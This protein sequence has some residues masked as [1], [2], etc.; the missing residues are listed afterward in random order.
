MEESMTNTNN[1]EVTYK[2]LEHIGIIDSYEKRGQIWTKEINVVA[3][4]GRAPKLDI[5]DWT[6]DENG[7][8]KMTRGITLTEEQAEKLAKHLSERYHVRAEKEHVSPAKEDM[9]R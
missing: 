7:N 8:L 1:N 4:N 9:A 6:T 5:R 2:I 3:W